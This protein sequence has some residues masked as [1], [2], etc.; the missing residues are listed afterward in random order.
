[1]KHIN[2]NILLTQTFVSHIN[3]TYLSINLQDPRNI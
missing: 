1:M 2:F 3:P